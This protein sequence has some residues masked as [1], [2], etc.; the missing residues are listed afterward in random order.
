MSAIHSPYHVAH[1]ALESIALQWP[2][3]AWLGEI[4]PAT[5]I[6]I[7][8]EPGAGKTTLA[9][10]LLGMIASVAGPVL[11]VSADEGIGL[12]VQQ[13]IERL[14]LDAPNY[15]IEDSWD[16][17]HLKTRVLERGLRGVLLDAVSAVDT[18][19]AR[20]TLAFLK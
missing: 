19:A 9:M 5:S 13:K 8:G 10:D 11:F 17:D 4:G 15:Y 2:Y 18:W 7:W 1:A 6:F 14:H 3:D 16:P 12:S 20:P